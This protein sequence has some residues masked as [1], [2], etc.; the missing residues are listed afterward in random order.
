[1]STAARVE[2]SNTANEYHPNM[3]TPHAAAGTKH[4]LTDHMIRGVLA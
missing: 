3:Y 2:T 4:A 1:V